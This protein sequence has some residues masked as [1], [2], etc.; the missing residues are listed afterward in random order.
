MLY[1]LL[2]DLTLFLHATFILFVVFG[3]VLIFWRRG[4]AW[5]HIPCAL[6]GIFIELQ[7]W[8]CPLTYL[9][10]DL[11]AMAGSQGYTGGFIDH[12]LM[13]LVYPSG[14]TSELQYRQSQQELQFRGQSRGIN[15][16]HQVVV[17]KDRKS[18]V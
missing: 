9:E 10:N 12:Y 11:R 16:R 14:L 3:G 13:P 15:Q 6:W 18:V 1:A 17:N 7:G 2:A 8:V 4:L 5:L